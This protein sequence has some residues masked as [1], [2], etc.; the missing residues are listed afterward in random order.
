MKTVP[1]VTALLIG[2][3][4]VLEHALAPLA[5]WHVRLYS[6]TGIDPSFVDRHAHWLQLLIISRSCLAVLCLALVFAAWKERLCPRGVVFALAFLWLI[7]V[8]YVL[9]FPTA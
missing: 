6:I 7:M 4:A 1:I 5:A 8:C 3:T 9:S 2:L